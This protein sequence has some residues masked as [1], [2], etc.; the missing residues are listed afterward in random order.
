VVDKKAATVCSFPPPLPFTGLPH[1]VSYSRRIYGAQQLLV[2]LSDSLTGVCLL[3]NESTLYSATNASLSFSV[4][5][6]IFAETVYTVCFECA[7][8]L[9]WD[10]Q[11]DQEMNQNFNSLFRVE[12]YLS[13]KLYKILLV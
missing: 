2:T 6:V 5:F 13:E 10:S 4:L 7:C 1:P 12:T 8:G 9:S 3:N 11:T